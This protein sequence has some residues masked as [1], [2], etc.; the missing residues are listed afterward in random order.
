MLM[1]YRRL[2]TKIVALLTIFSI[3]GLDSLSSLSSQQLALEE[4]TVTARKRSES[5]LEIPLSIT[6]FSAADIEEGA[7]RD[8]GDMALQTAGLQFSARSSDGVRGGRIDSVI[9]LR[10]VDFS[11]LDHLQA[12][13]VFVDGVFVLGTAS[14][15]GLQDLERVEI[16]K[17]PQSAFYGRN[18]FA[19]AVNYITKN[20][21]LTEVTGKVDISAATYGKYDGSLLVGIP[22]V[23]GKLAAQLNIKQYQTEGEWTA[24]DGGKLGQETTSSISGTLYGEPNE[25]LSFKFRV[26]YQKDNDG[27]PV[28]GVLRGE[29]SASCAGV[30]VQR[31]DE[32]GQIQ[33]YRPPL[34]YI[35]GE[36]PGLGEPG[37]PILSRETSLTPSL[38]ALNRGG[39]PGGIAPGP[40]PTLLIDRL[41]TGETYIK[42]VP[43]L[44]GYGTERDQLRL[45]FNTDYDFDNG[46]SFSFLAGWNDMGLNNMR[47]YDMSDDQV[48][49][50]SD[51]KFGRDWSIEAR[52]VSPQDGRFRWL[53][54]ATYYDQEFI[55]NNT[56]GEL[57]LS[58]FFGGGPGYFT[59]PATFGNQAKVKALFGSVSYDLSE[60]ITLD[61]E[62]RYSEDERTVNDSG[63]TFVDT[64]KEWTPRLILNY[65]PSDDTTVYLQASR[66]TLPGTTNG[67][68]VT[69]SNDDF[70][71]SYISPQT[72]QLS[73]ASECTQIAAQLTDDQFAGSTSAQ[74]LDAIELGWKQRALDNRLQFNISGWYY[75]WKNR[76]FPLAVTWVRDADTPAQRDRRPNDFANTQTV[77]VGGS[78]K[79]KGIEFESAFAITDSWDAQLNISW[80][81][82]KNTELFNNDQVTVNGG[83][84]NLKGLTNPR[85]PDVMAN[86]STTYEQPLAGDWNWYTRWDIIYSGEYYAGPSNLMEGPDYFLINPRLGIVRDNLRIE[87]FVRNLLQED[88]WA[89]VMGNRHYRHFSFDFRSFHAAI[90]SP[91]EKRT[92]GLRTNFTF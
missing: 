52:I 20:P 48:W 57:I 15:L 7:F 55:T 75:E 88:A 62:A 63:Q 41:L 54:G 80:Q 30:S 67:L 60:E 11:S 91:Q 38:L 6:A 36:P 3:F 74:T 90:V 39:G 19:G 82:S 1:F 69:C 26:H 86:F 77:S 10:G 71:E 9:R 8:L 47:D 83:F 73:T 22:L 65:Q 79:L 61:I 35:C 25:N 4:I 70:I 68:V 34:R 58:T 46:Y 13:S 49:Y 16:I 40:N 84:S 31:F 37:A 66:G 59:L 81:D 43:T 87:A 14:S 45:A 85:Y 53:A 44:D 24:N 33:T 56:G 27:S 17:G 23:E 2:S 5:L 89:T 92:I 12:T 76:P 28:T 42:S 72:G 50:S 29:D 78:L 18:T 64:Y 32:N 21:S 51:P